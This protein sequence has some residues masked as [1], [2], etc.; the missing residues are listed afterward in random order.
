M[1]DESIDP[2]ILIEFIDESLDSLAELPQLFIEMEQKPHDR[3]IIDTIFRPVHSIKGNSAF[4]G[5]LKLKKLTHEMETTLDKCRKGEL[6]AT[7]DIT[8]ILLKGLDQINSIFTRVREGKSEIE[9]QDAYNYLLEEVISTQTDPKNDHS[10]EAALKGIEELLTSEVLQNTKEHDKLKD[11]YESLCALNGHESN[12]PNESDTLQ[13]IL[14]ITTLPIDDLLDDKDVEKVET[15]LQELKE[16]ISN[17]QGKALYDEIMEEY[18][19]FVNAIGFDSLFAGLISDKLTELRKMDCLK[20]IDAPLEN[21]IEEVE[22]P[23]ESPD[24]T[25]EE[26]VNTDAKPIENSSKTMRIPEQTIDEF[27][28]FIGE[29]VVVREMYD[30]LRL[31]FEEEGIRPELTTELRRYTDNFRQVSDE[32]ERSCM[33]VRKQPIKTI[34]QKVPRIVREV[35][36]HLNKEIDVKINGDN[37]SIDKSLIGVLEAPIVHMIRN[38]AD[39]GI[40]H[41]EAR[42][43]SGKPQN[44]CIT[45]NVTDDDDS[46]FISINDNGK[47]LDFDALRAKGIELGIFREDQ[48]LS[49]EEISQV[50]FYS[51][52]STAEKVTDISGRGVGM[53][54]VK[55]YIE[56][57][58]G[59][60]KLSSITGQGSEF[61]ITMRKSITTQ[62]INGLIFKLDNTTYVI[63]LKYV[64]ESFPPTP[65]NFCNVY[66]KVEHIERHNALIPVLRLRELFNAQE[67]KTRSKT[68]GILI[69][70]DHNGKRLAVMADQILNIQQVVLKSLKGLHTYKE[71]ITGGALRGDGYISLIL[72]VE[73]IL[74]HNALQKQ[75]PE[76]LNCES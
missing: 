18:D 7:A 27:L 13:Q 54:V 70:V 21:S 25:V 19:T 64:V 49:E 6:I 20:E 44:G 30:H 55:R 14:D 71:L 22:L 47:G 37:L 66:D 29:L 15:L 33:N 48:T 11:I 69:V 38:A 23:L 2:S 68:E 73:Y 26:Q 39:H 53:D 62:I 52:V 50:I 32:L 43:A 31:K 72:N 16:Q 41:P 45:I 17:D 60:I 67:E 51:G 24:E 75:D 12:E 57:A 61:L 10:P 36:N 76:L 1:F 9:H 8:N 59:S 42:I 5:M 46:I 65:E 58:G 28:N 56:S 74:S 34:M 63:P 35:A 40:E 3:D 4:F